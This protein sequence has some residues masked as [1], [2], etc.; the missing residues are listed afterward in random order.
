MTR[1]YPT[2]EMNKNTC[3]AVVTRSLNRCF[4]FIKEF[5]GMLKIPRAGSIF[6]SLE[7]ETSG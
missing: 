7:K 1:F 6:S 4:T 5:D 2:E 3:E